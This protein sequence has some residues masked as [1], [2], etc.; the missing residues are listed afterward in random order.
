MGRATSKHVIF[1]QQERENQ[2]AMPSVFMYSTITSKLRKFEVKVLQQSS[3][4]HKQVERSPGILKL[5]KIAPNQEE[6]LYYDSNSSWVYELLT[7]LCENIDFE[8]RESERDPFIRTH[9][10][11]L[12]LFLNRKISNDLND[13]IVITGD[14]DA[15]FSLPCIRCLQPVREALA[16]K[17]NSCSLSEEMQERPEFQEADTV[18]ALGE[19][20]DLYFYHKREIDLKEM[21]HEYLYLNLPPLPLHDPS[22]KGLCLK[23]GANLNTTLCKHVKHLQ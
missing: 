1:S 23:C 11:K 19:E 15:T 9:D 21:V 5:A 13:H 17:V 16:L 7:E 22:C 14:I 8:G 6:S 10:L 18:F 2:I 4:N 20:R 3:L 12:N